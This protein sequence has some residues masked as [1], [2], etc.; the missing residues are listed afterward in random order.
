MTENSEPAV[1]EDQNPPVLSPQYKAAEEDSRLFLR[2]VGNT[3]V[4]AEWQP[5]NMD[6][7]Q[8]MGI[9]QFLLDKG[10][11]MIQMQEAEAA[12]ALAQNRIE[13]AGRVPTD[14]TAF[15]PNLKG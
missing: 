13:V 12:R 11:Q 9:G 2:F 4:L 14:P 15:P 5:I 6:A 10:K 7:F 1:A 3:A 8:L